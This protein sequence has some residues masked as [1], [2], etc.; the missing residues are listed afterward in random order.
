MA[1]TRH[2]AIVT[3]YHAGQSV[4]VGFLIGGK[5]ILTCA[6]VVNRA[7]GRDIDSPERPTDVLKVEFSLID[8]KPERKARVEHWVPRDAAGANDI[9]GLRLIRTENL[10]A[11]TRSFTFAQWKAGTK[12][13]LYGYPTDRP[14]EDG[15][16]A[17][18]TVRAGV[19]NGLLQVDSD[20]D[21]AFRVQPG[22]SG[23]PLV[24]KA[25][26][27]IGMLATASIQPEQKDS[28]AIPS[29]QLTTAWPTHIRVKPTRRPVPKRPIL[30]AAA[31][32]VLVAVLIA[33]RL[34]FGPSSN[35]SA[36]C[37]G[38]EV[39]VSTEKDELLGKLA[40]TYNA[41]GRT[42]GDGAC[43]TVSAS[44]LTSG[45]AMRALAAGWPADLADGRP[46]PQ[47]WLPTS[48]M[49]VD[50]LRHG[51][52]GKAVAPDPM[53]SITT[54]ALVIA[55]PERMVD[56]M[57]SRGDVVGWSDILS[58][59]NDDRGWGAFGH[60]E[61]GP[62]VL[63]RDNP[64]FST[65]GLAASVATYFAAL[66][67]VD[68]ITEAD[69]ANGTVTAF[70]RDI[71]SS[72][73]RYG[74]EATEFMQLLYDEDRKT[75]GVVDQPYVSAVVIQ[76]QL[77]YLYNKGAPTGDLAELATGREP[78]EKLV[79]V[80]PSEGTVKLD[81]PFVVLSSASPE[82]RA[83]AA[84]FSEF[85]VEE[86]Q[87]REFRELGFRDLS[88]QDHPTELLAKTVGVSTRDR[89][90][91]ITLPEPKVL[92]AIQQAFDATRKA[93]R[94]LLV[95]DVSDSMKN[96]ADPKVPAVGSKLDRLKPAAKRGLA[97]LGDDD[98]V[99]IWTFATNLT[100]EVPMSR[101]GDVRSGLA[102]IIDGLD[103]GGVTALYRTMRAANDEL[104]RTL[105][106]DRINAIVL[107]SDGLN[108]PR[109]DAGRTALLDAVDAANQETSVRIFTVPYGAD[110]DTELLGQI[111]NV[112]KARYYDATDPKDIDQVMVSVFSNFSPP[113]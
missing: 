10:P 5:R 41:A 1:R 66:G 89:Q 105:D 42:F 83:A 101:V 37:V 35:A 96:S 85:L 52:G 57:R 79:A 63:G 7:L 4:G 50:L 88:R 78:N 76:E 91:F 98:Q 13:E 62:F 43:A 93:A 26:R 24:N 70:V 54:S 23:T 59:A 111:A 30:I 22:Y 87:Q 36:P 69:L 38:L 84:D 104:Q 71:D 90:R 100:V 110:A 80:Q 56:A 53:P 3:F 112:T 55:M 8:G 94:V 61:W 47:V 72:V 106:H 31:A 34:V 6:H 68:G 49:W 73:L 60:P 99:G 58:L 12:V 97:L 27:V 51:G 86:A 9:A 82:Q 39:S 102:G 95:L 48:S 15:A 17:G 108:H 113:R 74:N 21:H 45:V 25:G 11:R 14:R 64:H 29:S 32:V 46:V 20:Q 44:G 107:L 77:V 92:Q 109:D 33:A 28:Y 103:A 19:G 67:R 75:R 18:G 16:W 2:H 81:H 65:S 40:T